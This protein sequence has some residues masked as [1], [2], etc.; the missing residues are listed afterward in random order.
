MGLLVGSC[1][2]CE[3]PV[4]L[5][6]DKPFP[7]TRCLAQDAPKPRGW[8]VGPLGLEL[9]GRTLA[10][11]GAPDS[12]RLA[13]FAGPG[14]A[15]P[16]SSGAL[17]AVAERE[18]AFAVM[19]G[20]VGDDD[21]TASETLKVLSEAA[22]PTLFVPGGR[23]DHRR[24]EALLAAL[25]E[26]A[27]AR[28]INLAAIR[29]VQVGDHQLIPVAGAAD[30]RYALNRHCCGFSLADLQTAAAELPAPTASRFLLAWQAP[31]RGGPHAV[32]R[33]AAGLDLG[34]DDL[35]EFSER[36]G[37]AG[38]L[39]AWP[40]VRVAE[41]AGAHRRAGEGA[42]TA[43]RTSHPE[44]LH[45]ADLIGQLMEFWGFKRNMG[46]LWCV[47]F[48]E[49]EPLSAPDLAERLSLSAGA[50][51][52]TLAELSKWGAVKKAWVPGE[53]RDY[54]QPETD[55]WK[56]V[57]RVFRER[58]LQQIQAAKEALGEASRR[59]ASDE[60]SGAGGKELTYARHR[61]ESLL[62][63]AEIGKR[64]LESVLEG[65]PID[66]APIAGFETEKP[67]ES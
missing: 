14:L 31:G 5:E 13:A 45:I 41:P 47:L 22:F 16:V 50:I 30:G 2:S 57:S 33:T 24:V 56:M 48:L 67:E 6:V 4:T 7:H 66:S 52:M 28:V 39:F 49:R 64:L 12:L 35:A 36:V 1:A 17:A 43:E 23:D 19:L 3:E 42:V 53:R 37:A 11:T 18:P 34:S 62:T 38:G 20:G 10:I 58:E 54:Y 51:S 32:A 25:P 60:A 61:I 15:E 63:L 59:L 40:V 9:S 46:R 55:I 26:A 44:I 65:K 27:R 8:Q 21:A 29:V